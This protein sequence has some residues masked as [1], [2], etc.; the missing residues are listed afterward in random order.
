MG[1]EAILKLPWLFRA[2]QCAAVDMN[3]LELDA[4]IRRKARKNRALT[5]I[6]GEDPLEQIDWLIEHGLEKLVEIQK[7]IE[8]ENPKPLVIDRGK[9]LA[10]IQKPIVSNRQV[11]E[12]VDP[13]AWY[14][15]QQPFFAYEYAISSE[16]IH[17]WI[18]S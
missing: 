12:K 15:K 2:R 7:W 1:R 11:V 17:Y 10:S 18:R 8:R 9:Q 4:E 14:I 3:K 5:D 16:V 13:T 6:I